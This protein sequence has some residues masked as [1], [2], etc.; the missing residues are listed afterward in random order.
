[1]T[2]TRA[3][4]GMAW[5]S[6]ATSVATLG[7]GGVQVPA[8]PD[9]RLQVLVEVATTNATERP[10]MVSLDGTTVTGFGGAEPGLSGISGPTLWPGEGGRVSV[11][12]E[13]AVAG[14]PVGAQ[15]GAEGTCRVG[16][17][18]LAS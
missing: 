10:V 4:Q 18:P 11:G 3:V 6:I 9:T 13:P 7:D 5:L 14:D 16:F 2:R 8:H 12:S 17:Y 15:P 1:M